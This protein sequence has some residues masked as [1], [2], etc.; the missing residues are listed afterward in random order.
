[1]P[2]LTDNMPAQKPVA[3]DER[4]SSPEEREKCPGPPEGLLTSE[5]QSGATS[6]RRGEVRTISALLVPRPATEA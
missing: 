6:N 5:R 1:M 3:S 2:P 4:F